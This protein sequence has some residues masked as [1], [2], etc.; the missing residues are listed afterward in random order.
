MSREKKSLKEKLGDTAAQVNRE[1][2]GDNFAK[3]SIELQRDIPRVA[4]NFNEKLQV[5]DVI[6]A[7]KKN[8]KIRY[9]RSLDAG[10]EQGMSLCLSEIRG[11][12]V[13]AEELRSE[14]A[15]FP[16]MVAGLYEQ[17]ERIFGLAR[18]DQEVA[19][20]KVRES[21]KLLKEA[22]ERVRRCYALMGQINKLNKNV[23]DFVRVYKKE[24]KVFE[25]ELKPQR[26]NSK[27]F[28]LEADDPVAP[29]ELRH[30]QKLKDVDGLSLPLLLSYKDKEKAPIDE[31]RLKA[32]FE[33]SETLKAEFGDLKTYIEFES[34]IVV[35]ILKSYILRADGGGERRRG[36]AAKVALQKCR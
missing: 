29:G 24:K 30:Y 3:L 14:L 16:E 26:D 28:W 13:R 36:F 27:G 25:D 12:N 9:Q 11:R 4:V 32:S 1:A 2:G 8:S 15:K 34:L 19:A 31:Q 20:A 21:E 10:D 5:L 6:E 33:K 7:E 35:Q 23:E 18:A 22:A 17:K